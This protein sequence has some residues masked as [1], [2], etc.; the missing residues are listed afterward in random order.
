[1]PDPLIEAEQ[2]AGRA[3]AWRGLAYVVFER[4]PLDDF[5]NRI[6]M[7][8]FEVVRAVGE[9]EPHRGDTVIPGATEHGYALTPVSDG[10]APARS[11]SS[12]AIRS[13][14]TPTGRPPSTSCWRCARTSNRW[15]W[16]PPGWAPI[17]APV[18]RIPSLRRGVGGGAR[19]GPVER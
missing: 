1:M 3:P 17:C 6:P 13:A 11:A 18:L 9:L 7:L 8:Q 10:H 16:S 14:P 12:T 4:L 5:G 19:A 15:R 2:G